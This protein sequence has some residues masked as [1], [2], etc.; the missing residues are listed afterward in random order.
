MIEIGWE[1]YRSKR[2]SGDKDT[3]RGVREIKKTNRE[4]GA[5]DK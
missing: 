3:A 2:Q 4:E 1:T 5:G